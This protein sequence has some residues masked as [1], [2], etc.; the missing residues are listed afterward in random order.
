MQWYRFGKT[1]TSLDLNETELRENYALIHIYNNK[2]LVVDKSK[3]DI[4]D[5]A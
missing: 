2:G 3:I 5:I 4:E 1:K